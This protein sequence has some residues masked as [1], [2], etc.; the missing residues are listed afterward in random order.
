M[1]V[2]NPEHIHI[3]RPFVGVDDWNQWRR[4]NP[5]IRPDLE[6]ADL[7]G[8]SLDGA[9]F[10]G[11]DLTVAN[12]RETNLNEATLGYAD[13]TEADLTGATLVKASLSWTTFVK[14]NL[15]EADL[16]GATLHKAD[17]REANLTRANLTRAF[18]NEA[19][20]VGADLTSTKLKETYLVGAD[21][22]GVNFKWANLMGANLRE[23]NLTRA[24]LREAILTGLRYSFSEVGP[25]GVIRPFL[26]SIDLAESFHRLGSFIIGADL[27]KANL[28]GANLTR[29]DLT[30]VPLMG[31]NLTGANLTGANLTDA[32]LTGANLTGAN[33]TGA[34]I[35]YAILVE[36]NF[37]NA[38]LHGCRVYGCSAW[39]LTLKDTEQHDLIISKNDEP[40]ITVDDLEVAQFLSLLLNNKKIRHVIDKITSKVVLILGRFTPERKAILDAIRKELRNRNFLPILFDFE[41][42]TNRSFTETVSTLA[43]MARFVI[44]DITEAKSITQELQKIVP[45][46]PH[47]PVQPIL[48]GGDS[49]YAMF[50][51]FRF[52]PWV[53]PIFIYHNEQMLLASIKEKVIKPAEV[54]AKEQATK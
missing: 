40:E 39:N 48:L 15:T 29:V 10:D 49:G 33:L 34:N 45:G 27:T 16:T 17:L 35:S 51:D 7:T 5:D 22:M 38:K 11:I 6:K 1:I 41:K 32:N 31:A 43:H 12:L 13:L 36:T 54:M 3:L 18:I 24:D 21:L 44:A 2:A 28:T 50:E 37:T 14:A 8:A 23:A 42:P 9:D 46:L 30:G 4:K 20:L 52:Y 25:S 19:N 53:L 47:L 26:Q